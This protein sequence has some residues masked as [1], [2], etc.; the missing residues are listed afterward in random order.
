MW[1]K[2]YRI[3]NNTNTRE[4]RGIATEKYEHAIRCP[5]RRSCWYSGIK[6][7]LSPVEPIGQWRGTSWRWWLFRIDRHEE[8]LVTSPQLS[9]IS[10]GSERKFSDWVSV[11]GWMRSDTTQRGW[12]RESCG[13]GTTSQHWLFQKVF[14]GEFDECSRTQSCIRRTAKRRLIDAN[15]GKSSGKKVINTDYQEGN[16][17]IKWYF[18]Q[19]LA[20]TYSFSSMVIEIY[21]IRGPSI[22]RFFEA[23]SRFWRCSNSCNW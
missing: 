15:S 9:E 3:A 17:E 1:C 23:R 12:M 18:V 16:D 11:V 6:A 8:W 5:D 10:R 21:R 19:H 4:E 14:V 2:V 13:T 22:S 20:S 7:S